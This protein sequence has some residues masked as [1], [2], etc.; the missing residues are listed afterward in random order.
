MKII[1]LKG[2]I[3]LQRTPIL[4][5]TDSTKLGRA[6]LIKERIQKGMYLRQQNMSGDF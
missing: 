1:E 3:Y 5:L 4:H 6:F 2:W